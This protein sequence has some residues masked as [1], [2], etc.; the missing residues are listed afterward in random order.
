MKYGSIPG[1]RKSVSRL[2]MGI[3]FGQSASE[4]SVMFDDFF[5]AGGNCFD[6]AYVYGDGLCER[7][8]GQWIKDRGLREQVVILS[9]GAHTP[10]CNPKDLTLQFMESLQRLQTE[11]VDI[12]MMHRDNPEIPVGEFMDA[13]NEH[14]KAGRMRAFGGSN[15]SLARVEAANEYAASKG[16]TGFAAV[17]N[18]L[19]LARM[20]GPRWAGCLSVGDAASRAWFTRWVMLAPSAHRVSA[21]GRLVVRCR[22]ARHLVMRTSAVDRGGKRFL[23]GMFN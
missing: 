15:W 17:S 5:A 2:V 13:L 16:L 7:L 21:R 14:Q 23:S 8:L 4:A 10:F 22:R 9:K 1:I 11:Y 19:S 12:Y 6:S 20:V 3:G 18:Q